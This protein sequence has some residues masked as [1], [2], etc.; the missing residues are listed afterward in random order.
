MARRRGQDLDDAMSSINEIEA[1]DAANESGAQ[2]TAQAAGTAK[3]E[4][5]KVEYYF[6]NIG[7]VAI[8]LIS[9]LKVGDLIEIGDD[10]EHIRQ[11]VESMQIDRKDVAEAYEGDSVGIKTKYKVQVGSSVYRIDA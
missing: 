1:R 9:H 5:G 11:R 3:V 10:E 7:V 2:S 6:S 4:V 8:K